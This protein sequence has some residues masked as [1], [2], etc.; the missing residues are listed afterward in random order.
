MV[1]KPNSWEPGENFD[2]ALATACG[3][4]KGKKRI[5]FNRD[6]RGNSL[7]ILAGLSN[8]ITSKKTV[9]KIIAKNS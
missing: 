7:T 8:T 3:K 1:W 5:K 2:A 9:E 4:R 6:R